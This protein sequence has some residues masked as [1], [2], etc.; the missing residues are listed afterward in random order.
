MRTDVIKETIWNI[1]EETDVSVD[2]S[3]ENL[4]DGKILDSI[5]LVEIVSEMTEVFEIDIPYEEIIPE[6]FNSID[7]MVR[8]VEKYV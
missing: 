1:C 4:V 2:F 6:N 7:A 5:T 3:E 8:L